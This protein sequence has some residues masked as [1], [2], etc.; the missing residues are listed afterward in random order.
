MFDEVKMFQFEISFEKWRRF[1]NLCF[2]N[3]EKM[4]YI[5]FFP[6]QAACLIKVRVEI[7]SEP[8]EKVPL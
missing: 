4:Y 1:S 2:W 7:T 5:I 6:P 8:K 3:G